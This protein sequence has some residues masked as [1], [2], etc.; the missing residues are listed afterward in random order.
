M[1]YLENWNFKKRGNGFDIV[2]NSYNKF[3]VNWK[4][5]YL[6]VY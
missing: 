3:Y 6:S 4:K 2:E 5:N 1:L